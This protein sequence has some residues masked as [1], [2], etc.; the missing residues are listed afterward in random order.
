MLTKSVTIEGIWD[1]E[2]S[3]EPVG[4]VALTVPPYTTSTLTIKQIYGV[5]DQR[6]CIDL[7]SEY[8]TPS[9][10]PGRSCRAQGPMSVHEDVPVSGYLRSSSLRVTTHWP[11]VPLQSARTAPLGLQATLTWP[12]LGHRD[13]GPAAQHALG[14]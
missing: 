8:V 10:A 12:I 4:V 1:V 3:W 5:P 11:I 9:A 2:A 7:V 6:P 14:L 13:A